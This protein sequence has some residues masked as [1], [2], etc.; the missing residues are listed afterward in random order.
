[1]NLQNEPISA[2]TGIMAERYHVRP[3]DILC[4][5]EDLTP[6]EKFW[7]DWSI[8]ARMINLNKPPPQKSGSLENEIIRKREFAASR[9]SAINA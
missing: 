3:S 1:M 8:T 5:A 7:L 9:G 4:P 2:M 6:A